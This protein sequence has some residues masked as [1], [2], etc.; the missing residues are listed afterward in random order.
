MIIRRR[1]EEQRMLSHVD[2]NIVEGF[3]TWCL[4]DNF[5]RKLR[6]KLSAEDKRDS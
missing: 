1:S 4:G 6:R 5:I 2:W 3:G